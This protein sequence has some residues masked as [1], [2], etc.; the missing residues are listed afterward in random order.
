MK[1]RLYILLLT[2][3]LFSGSLLAQDIPLDEDGFPAFSYKE[4]DTTYHMR[5]Y[6]FVMLKAGPNRDQDSTEVQ[7]I[8]AGHM[9]FM[10]EMAEKGYLAIAGPFGDDGDWRGIYIYNVNSVEKVRELVQQDP[11]IQ[12]GRLVADIRPWWSARGAKLP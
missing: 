12:S 6:V 11:A 8:Q 10:N 5:Q 2:S 9:A 3:F 1:V 4:G 7:R